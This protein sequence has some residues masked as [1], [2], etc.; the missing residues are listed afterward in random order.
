M[1]ER[2]VMDDTKA[3]A[4]ALTMAYKD[5]EFLRRWVNYYGRQFGR[6]H[7]YVFSH[8]GDPEHDRIAEGCNV[9]SV[10]RDE[11]GYKFDQ[12]RWRMINNFSAGLMRYYSWL[13]V[14][15][16]DELVLLDPEAGDN[17]IDYLRRYEHGGDPEKINAI[18]KSI[19][20]FGVELIHNPEVEPEPID[21]EQPILRKRRVF[22][23]NANYSKP[24]VLRKPANFTMGGHANNHQPRFLDPH[25]YLLHLRFYDFETSQQRLADRQELR[26]VMDK[27]KDP[28]KTGHAWKK[29][30][31][32][33]LEL[34]K[35][36]P[37]GE[38]CQ[39]E[40]FRRR[41]EDEKQ[42]LHNG[43]VTFWGGGRSKE[44][45]WLPERF[46]DLV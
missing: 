32:N 36:R 17:L 21:P 29:D 28:A 4:G 12:R 34:S 14:S 33:F 1:A 44:L 8:G 11:T 30:L 25:L 9:I 46:A 16:V 22:R 13:I 23:A 40:A 3:P 39:L 2:P 24:C 5:Y 38:D 15:D 6:E 35:G 37:V 19:S 7:L 20:P 42:H 10:P 18:P 26:K 27:G 31:K 45:Y 43:K 41:M